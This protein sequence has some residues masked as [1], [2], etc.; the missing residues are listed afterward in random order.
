MPPLFG[1]VER[2]P[3]R[4]GCGSCGAQARAACGA[5][6]KHRTKRAI[7]SAAGAVGCF[8]VSLGL[9]NLLA[10]EWEGLSYFN[11]CADFALCLSLYLILRRVDTTLAGATVHQRVQSALCPA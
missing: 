9:V 1:W 4:G 7:A 3:A 10:R 5:T 6:W 11:L 8:S 2:H